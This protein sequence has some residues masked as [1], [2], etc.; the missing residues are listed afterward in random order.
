MWLLAGW[1]DEATPN[2]SSLVGSYSRGAEPRIQMET[3][4]QAWLRR[5][6]ASSLGQKWEQMEISH[7]EVYHTD[8]ITLICNSRPK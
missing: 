8:T 3:G 7:L 2:L 6:G 1:S 4:W 5:H